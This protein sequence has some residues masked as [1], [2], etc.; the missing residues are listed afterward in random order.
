MR[1]LMRM[2]LR[3]LGTVVGILVGVTG[4]G[5]M[6]LSLQIPSATEGGS[7]ASLVLG[8]LLGLVMTVVGF[9]ASAV[10]WLPDQE[11]P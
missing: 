4:L 10:V 8:V 2:T 6:R 3:V 1:T 11:K 7:S 5:L 9:I